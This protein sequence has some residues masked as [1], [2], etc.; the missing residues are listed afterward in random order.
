MNNLNWLLRAVQWA[1]N[2]PSEKRVILVLV[3]IAICLAIVG[4]QHFGFWPDWATMDRPRGMR[5]I[6]P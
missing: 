2:P 6:R 5:A 4:L 3:V 1:R